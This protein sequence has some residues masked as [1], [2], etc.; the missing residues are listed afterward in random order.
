MLH[1]ISSVS[2]PF[3]FGTGSDLKNIFYNFL[4]SPKKIDVILLTYNFI[5]IV[6]KYI[7]EKILQVLLGF[8]RPDPEVCNERDPK[9]WL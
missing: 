3:N 6:C 9:H 7:I 1:I 2:D 5:M 8:I 4:I